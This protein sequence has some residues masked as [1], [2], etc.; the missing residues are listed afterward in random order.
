MEN[1]DRALKSQL[2]LRRCAKAALLLSALK[3]LPIL[4][5]DNTNY[6]DEEMWRREIQDLRIE[7]LKERM[8]NKKIRPCTLVEFIVQIMLLMSLL[9]LILIFVLKTC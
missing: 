8:K 6:R 3:S 2:A 5:R 7:L 9:S 1:E 4:D